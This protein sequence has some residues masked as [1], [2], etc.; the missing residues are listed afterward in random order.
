LQAWICMNTLEDR[1][2]YRTATQL[3]PLKIPCLI[4]YYRDFTFT[5]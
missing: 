5:A 2:R 3:E 1:G 4:G